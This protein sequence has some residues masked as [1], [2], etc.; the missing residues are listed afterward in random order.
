M[1][2]K[3]DIKNKHQYYSEA[4]SIRTI[5]NDNLEFWMTR[6]PEPLKN[7]PIINLAIPGKFKYFLCLYNQ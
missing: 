6:L 4:Y 1:E 7:L 2:R 5:S 3:Y